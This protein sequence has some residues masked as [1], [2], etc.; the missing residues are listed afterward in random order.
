MHEAQRSA[1]VHPSNDN[2]LRNEKS[3]FK[4]RQCLGL[5]DSLERFHQRSDAGTLRKKHDLSPIPPEQRN[6]YEAY[7]QTYANAAAAAA[8]EPLPLSNVSEPIVIA[9]EVEIAADYKLHYL[10]RVDFLANMQKSQKGLPRVPPTK[11]ARAERNL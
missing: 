6:I 8:A 11:E 10:A 3:F 1:G 5:A 9:D 2:E 4:A 7:Y